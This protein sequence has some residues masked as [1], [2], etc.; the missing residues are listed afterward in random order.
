[1]KLK[2]DFMAQALVKALAGVPVTLEITILTMLISA[3]LAF[4]MALRRITKGNDKARLIR[5]YVSFIR[6]TPIVLQILFFYS[7][8]PTLLN[9]LF[10]VLLKWDLNIWD[11]NPIIYAVAVFTLNTAAVLSEVF[12]SALLSV[13]AG[14]LEA[15]LASGLTSAQAYRRII[16]PQALVVALPNI[17]STVVNV[18]KSTSLAYLMTVQDIMAIAKKEAAFGYNYIEAYLVVLVIYIVLCTIVQ[19]I[20]K[21]V[22]G[23]LSAYRK[24]LA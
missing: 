6:G 11:I 17:C 8:L 16:I 2:T 5:F 21:T 23:S 4:W 3:P 24:R 18:L 10:N 22:E 9:Y 20:F 13:G 7:L 15:A 12:R 14:Q 19:L 1:M